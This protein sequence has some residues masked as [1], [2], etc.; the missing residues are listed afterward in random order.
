VKSKTALR[1]D[2]A[3][4]W[5]LFFVLYAASKMDFFTRYNP[6]G[7][8]QYL[9]HDSIYWVAMAATAFFIWLIEVFRSRS[10]RY[11]LSRFALTIQLL[12]VICRAIS[13]DSLIH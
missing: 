1:I 12:R 2:L 7:I 3:V 10:D 5:A 8:G 13:V 4:L 9:Q 11:P 6:S